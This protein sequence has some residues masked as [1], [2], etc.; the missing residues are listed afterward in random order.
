MSSKQLEKLIERLGLLI[1][2]ENQYMRKLTRM[3]L[4]NIG[5]K[6]IFEA[7][8]GLAALDVIR[9][10]NPDIMLLDWETPVLS[11]PQIMHIVRSP[12]LFAKPL[13]PI[14][15][16]TTSASPTRVNEAIRL[17]VHEVL[18]KPTSPKMLQDRLLSI[19]VN[20]R[21]MVQ[22]GKYF[23]PK[24]RRQDSGSDVIRVA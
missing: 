19:L 7:A 15:M 20:P 21:P 9:S 17:G 14:I 13:L 6:S 2:D 1:V 23:V 4:M 12:G 3:M 5:A 22:I 11:G 16:L 8:D 10:V 18:T 24:P